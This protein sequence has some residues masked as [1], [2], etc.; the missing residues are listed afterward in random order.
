VDSEQHTLVPRA[1][2]VTHAFRRLHEEGLVYR[3]TYMVNWAPKLQT[4]VSD[5]EVEYSDESGF[6]YYFK[7]PLATEEGDG[8][9]VDKERDFL[10]IA[11]TRPETILGDAAVAVYPEDARFSRF[12]GREVEVPMSGGRRIPVIAGAQSPDLRYTS[13]AVVACSTFVAEAVDPL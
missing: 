6:L 2:A 13:A 11:T 3:G 9:S 5:L 8:G 10:P 4:A 7:Y 12:V 1:G